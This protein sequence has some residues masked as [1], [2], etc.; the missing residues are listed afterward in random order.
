MPCSSAL[1]RR[2]LRFSSPPHG[3]C[4]RQQC[5]LTRQLDRHRDLALVPAASAG[6]PAGLDLAP[7]AHEAAE[8]RHVL[9]VDFV[10]LLLAE[11]A[12]ATPRRVDGTAL[13][14]RPGLTLLLGIQVP[15]SGVSMPALV[16]AHREEYHLRATDLTPAGRSSVAVTLAGHLPRLTGV[17]QERGSQPSRHRHGA[18]ER[19]LQS[20]AQA[21]LHHRML[22]GPVGGPQL[23][24]EIGPVRNGP[25]REYCAIP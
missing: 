10:N 1:P 12:V 20:H 25:Y 13:P 11:G 3:D 5:H 21:P 9:V 14:G 19:R 15:L 6:D 4:V 17:P 22:A 23:S 18:P 2:P 7:V 16:P 24:P 8:G